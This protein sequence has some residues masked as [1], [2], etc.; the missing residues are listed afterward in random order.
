MKKLRTYAA[1]LRTAI[2][3]LTILPVESRGE[4]SILTDRPWL[5]QDKP[6]L[7]QDR[8]N[9]GQSAG[10]FPWVGVVIGAGA[11]LAWWLSGL[12]LPPMLAA[13]LAGAAWAALTGGLHLDGLAD[14]CDGLLSAAPA[15]RRLEI[16]RDP[17]LGTFGVAGLCLVLVAKITAVYSLL[18]ATTIPAILLAASSGRLLILLARRQP[19]ARAGGMGEDFQSGLRRASL[20][21]AAVPVIGLCIFLGW[22]GV[23]AV[24]AALLATLAVFRL[25]RGRIGGLTGDVL[26]CA[27]EISELAVLLACNLRLPV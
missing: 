25:A 19:S 10:W 15:E 27:V 23:L 24:L 13:V 3:F 16:L 7:S 4:A 12:V 18:P 21:L 2:G 11:G 5:R 1:E 22:S 26:G 9:L 20:P 6:W 8:P 14:C 17:R